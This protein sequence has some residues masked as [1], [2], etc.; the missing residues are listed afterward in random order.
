MPGIVTSDH[1]NKND[2]KGPDVGFE[3]G[4]RDKIAMFVEALLNGLSGE[5]G[6]G[7]RGKTHLGSNKRGFLDQSPSRMRLEKRVRNPRGTS[8]NSPRCKAHSPA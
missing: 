5:K 4:I 2:T 3:G 7:D 8:S 6:G 1:V